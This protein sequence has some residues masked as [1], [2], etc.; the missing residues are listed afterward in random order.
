MKR[1]FYLVNLVFIILS[2][3]Y[4]P[5]A[6][7]INYQD[8]WWNPAESGWGVNIAQQS[9]TLFATWFIYGPNREPY[10][11]VMPGTTRVTSQ[12]PNE[13]IYTGAIYQTRAT[14]FNVS[15]FVPITEVT[16]VGNATFRF[17]SARDGVLTYN[18]N[19][20]TVTKNITRQN[21]VPL[22]LSGT[23]YGGFQRNAI[24]CTNNQN[25]GSALDQAIYVVSVAAQTTSIS[26]NEVGGD[27]CRF[28]GNYTQYGSTFEGAGAYTCNGA[29][30]NWIA[31]EGTST[32]STIAM[33]LNL[34]RSGETCT[35]TGSIGGFKPS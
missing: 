28:T 23:Y 16:Q 9:D 13:F 8:L 25:N 17:S 32:E 18:I 10:W 34:T 30:G 19:S 27:S 35:I 2:A 1:F 3:L 12:L 14:P 11:I 24:G 4:S 7:A 5:R 15:P 20:S 31:R 22:S 29:T 21:I 26:I 6:S 33:R